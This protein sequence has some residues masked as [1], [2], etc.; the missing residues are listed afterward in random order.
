M[1]FT[2]SSNQALN[3][4]MEGKSVMCNMCKQVV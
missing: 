1:G 2:C 3:A 4:D